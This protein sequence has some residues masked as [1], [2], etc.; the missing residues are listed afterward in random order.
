MSERP[1]QPPT[2]EKTLTRW[3]LEE[4]KRK[5]VGFICAGLIAMVGAVWTDT[6]SYAAETESAVVTPPAPNTPST[7]NETTFDVCIGE[8]H[9]CDRN[10]RFVTCG[11][12]VED[13]IKAQC[14]KFEFTAP[15]EVRGDGGMCGYL[16][17]HVKCTAKR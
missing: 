12:N 11:T 4:K 2:I 7:E 5:A 10:V 8:H 1:N 16:V 6:Y 15:R 3:M 9:F 13:Y 14:E 17:Y